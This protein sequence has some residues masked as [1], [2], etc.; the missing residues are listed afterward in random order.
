MGKK[1]KLRKKIMQV[2]ITSLVGKLSLP[3]INPGHYR[4]RLFIGSTQIFVSFPYMKGFQNYRRLFTL[5]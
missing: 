3:W 4:V 5:R 1:R 2:F